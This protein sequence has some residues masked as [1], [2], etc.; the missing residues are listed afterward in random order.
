MR[1]KDTE[2]LLYTQ[3]ENIMKENE[4][5][6]ESKEYEYNEMSHPLSF[7]VYGMDENL[8]LYTIKEIQKKN[9][10]KIK[11]TGEIQAYVKQITITIIWFGYSQAYHRDSTR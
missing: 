9:A 5:E 11:I 7:I 1:S 10:P 3:R 8:L 6:R 2:D 4:R